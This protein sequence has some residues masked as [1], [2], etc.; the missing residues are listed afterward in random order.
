MSNWRN[1]THG[2]CP[3]AHSVKV[4]PP[5]EWVRGDDE[6]FGVVVLSNGKA[7]VKTRCRGCGA[8][9]SALPNDIIGRWT[10][11][12]ADF[13]WSKTN[14]PRE[15]DPCSV[16]DCAVTPTEYHHFAPRNTFGSADA[17]RWPVLPLCRGHHVQ[18]HQRMDGYA[19]HRKGVA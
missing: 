3:L 13:T 7:Q 6:E 18:W 17:N 12:L 4:Y 16:Q 2:D 9:S 11:T 19:W 8:K 14:D 1:R 5:G 10:L 15:Y